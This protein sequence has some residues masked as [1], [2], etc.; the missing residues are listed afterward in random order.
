MIS[1]CTEIATSCGRRNRKSKVREE[2]DTY[3]S[4]MGINKIKHTGKQTK[5]S[6]FNTIVPDPIRSSL[7]ACSVGLKN[8]SVRV[9][10]K[11]MV[12]VRF[13]IFSKII[14]IIQF[15]YYLCTR[16]SIQFQ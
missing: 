14:Q 2:K 5:F 12:N 7:L 11:V 6:L 8:V 1:R 4:F 9:S 16:Y 10:V 15:F 13:N 3:G